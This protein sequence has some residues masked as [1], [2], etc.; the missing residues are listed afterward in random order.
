MLLHRILSALVLAPLTVAAIFYGSWLFYAL[1]AFVFVI[2]IH[3]WSRLSVRDGAVRWGLMLGGVPYIGIACLCAV[4]LRSFEPGGVYLLFYVLFAIW[5]CD[6]GA[7]AFGRAIGGPKMAPSISPNKTWAGM[8]GGALSAA[9]V[10][11]A[12]DTW[13]DGRVFVAQ[14][15]WYVHALLGVVL[16]FVG[17]GG[18]LLE[19]AMKRRA[20][21]KDS[22]NIIPG[23]G[24]V[25]D[26]VDALLTTLPL[27]AI[28]VMVMSYASN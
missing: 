19:S 3:E 26:R 23:H 17:Q 16:A 4:W 20:G 11:M 10:L 8:I 22:G 15:A 21:L 18:D 5:A 6:I 13:L 27:F 1:M 28:I 2:G 24:G 7:Y 14:Y 12:Y 25:L 9:I